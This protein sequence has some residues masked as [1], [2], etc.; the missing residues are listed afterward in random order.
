LISV[1]AGVFRHLLSFQASLEFSASVFSL[2]IM[3]TAPLF[4]SVA[5]VWCCDAYAMEYRGRETVAPT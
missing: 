3:C 2:V 1:V 4:L 5:V